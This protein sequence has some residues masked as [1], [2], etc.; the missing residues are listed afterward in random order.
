MAGN[1]ETSDYKNFGLEIRPFPDLIPILGFVTSLERKRAELGEDLRTFYFPAVS[2]KD[3][4]SLG[5]SDWP[6]ATDMSA[7]LRAHLY[8]ARNGI[9]IGY[10]MGA[11]YL[12]GVL[13]I[14]KFL[15][16]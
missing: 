15:G 9:F 2:L 10:H 1:P 6:E 7:A 16:S 3:R 13:L 4:L 12:A 14:T 8:A 11:T 5:T